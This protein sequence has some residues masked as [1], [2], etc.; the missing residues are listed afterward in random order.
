[1]INVLWI[2]NIFILQAGIKCS[3]GMNK[4]CL[5]HWEVVLL[6]RH[7]G[8]PVLSSSVGAGLARKE[9]VSEEQPKQ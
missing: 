6:P 3:V 1:M 2:L 8:S 7:L 9:T 5:N 4:D